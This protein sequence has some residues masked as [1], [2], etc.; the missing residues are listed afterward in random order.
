MTEEQKQSIDK[1]E[2]IE[3]LRYINGLMR[4]MLEYQRRNMVDIGIRP[5][6]FP[7]FVYEVI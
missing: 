6:K 7:D 1:D 5:A 4:K 3:K 2:K